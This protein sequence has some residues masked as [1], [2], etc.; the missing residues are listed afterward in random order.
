MSALQSEGAAYATATHSQIQIPVWYVNIG[1]GC[2]LTS[3][4]LHQIQ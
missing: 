1:N 2:S 4:I 3:N